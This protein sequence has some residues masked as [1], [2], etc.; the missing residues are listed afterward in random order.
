MI[1]Y[2]YVTILKRFKALISIQTR[3]LPVAIFFQYC[4]MN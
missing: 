4:S 3:I 1:V 2:T